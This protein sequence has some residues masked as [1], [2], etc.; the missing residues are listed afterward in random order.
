M[1][2]KYWSVKE[3]GFKGIAVHTNPLCFIL[4]FVDG[5]I[6]RVPLDMDILRRLE[7]IAN[8]HPYLRVI[9]GGVKPQDDVLRCKQA[10]D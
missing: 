5:T 4:H 6:F 9:A 8:A 3:I 1:L 2:Q 10:N 7:G